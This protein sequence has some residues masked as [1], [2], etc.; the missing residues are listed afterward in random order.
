MVAND[1]SAFE[2]P[3]DE[4]PAFD[5]QP[6]TVS[7]DLSKV[8]TFLAGK[9]AEVT[10]VGDE[11]PVNKIK[12]ELYRII[13]DDDGERRRE[14]I[15]D[16]DIPIGINKDYIKEMLGPGKYI[17][18]VKGIDGKFITSKVLE[19]QQENKEE[20]DM[21]QERGSGM[22]QDSII[23]REYQELKRKFDKVLDEN[24]AL[25]RRNGQL[26]NEIT[27]V[28]NEYELKVANYENKVSNLNEKIA[29]IKSEVAARNSTIEDLKTKI[30]EAKDETKDTLAELKSEI[31]D[32]EKTVK[33]LEDNNRELRF[34]NKSLQG[35]L[36]RMKEELSEKKSQI[37]AEQAELTSLRNVRDMLKDAKRGSSADDKLLLA[38]IE[39]IAGKSVEEIKAKAR[40]EEKR[41]EADRDIALAQSTANI[42][43][44]ELPEGEEEPEELPPEQGELSKVIGM[45]GKNFAEPIAKLLNQ[46]GFVVLKQ[47]ELEEMLRKREELAKKEMG[48]VIKERVAGKK[49]K[50]AEKDV[51]KTT[52]TKEEKTGGEEAMEEVS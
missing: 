16:M 36:T 21:F 5:I 11:D 51:K 10:V 9:D 25:T 38:L 35:E 6:K 33:T 27:K 31:K 24:N 8:A 44:E 1:E 32:Y 17:F 13:T 7:V 40:L 42:G 26:E 29:Q 49:K 50:A 48:K 20:V 43:G 18:I 28:R 30:K 15:V 46:A 47:G 45:F 2:R 52:E 4:Q 23:G 39:S 22:E 37:M 12:P 3:E 14:K 19:F 41:L 34:D